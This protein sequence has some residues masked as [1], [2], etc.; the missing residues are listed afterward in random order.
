M[1]SSEAVLLIRGE[2][3]TT[4]TLSIKR[5]ETVEPVDVKIKRDVIPIETVYAEMLDDGIAHIHLTSFS[6]GTYDELLVA[7]DEMEAKGMKGLVIDVRQNP[8]GRLDIAIK[9][10]D[11]FLE[12]GK[13]IFQY[14]EKELPPEMYPATGKRKSGSSGYSRHR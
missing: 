9:I 4:V 7:L 5:G 8:G 14:K 2:K 1:S 11:L 13:N 3:G 12:N 6:E 10:S